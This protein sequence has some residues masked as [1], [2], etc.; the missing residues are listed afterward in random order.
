MTRDL[1]NRV[2][3]VTGASRNIGRATSVALASRGAHIIIHVAQDT[4]AAGETVKAVEA[5]GSSATIVTGDLS[6]EDIANRV[7]AE[8]A[9]ARGRLDFVINNAAIRPESRL[10]DLTFAEWRRVMSVNLDA[11]FLVCRAAVPHL[12]GSDNG[13]II[14]LGGLTG[15]TG[16]P[17]RAHVVASKAA[18]AGLTRALAQDLGADGI[19]VNCVS[20]GLIATDRSARGGRSPKHHSSRANLLGHR[21]QA[22]DVAETIAFLCSPQA[23]YITGQTIHVNGGAY[24]A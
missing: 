4:Q 9:A 11:V 13:A 16:A 20:P 18:I 7:V 12:R 21:G 17:E 6:D 22:Q 8:A 19:T 15:H 1:E 3:L 5:A 2:A 14:C 24:L 10:D 23:R